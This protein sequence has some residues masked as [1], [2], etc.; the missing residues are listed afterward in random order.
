MYRL[1]KLL[2][3]IGI[4]SRR[5]AEDLIISG[6]V[7]IN[8]IEAKI[9]DKWQAGDQLI[10]NDNIID[11]S[12]FINQKIE[13]IK[14][15]KPRGEVVS[16]QDKFN[17]NNVFSKLPPVT[18]KWISIGRLDIQ[19]TGLILFT[20]DGDLAHKIM[21]P[22][23]SLK[24][25]YYVNTNRALTKDDIDSLLNG[26][27]INKSDLGKFDSIDEIADKYYRLILSTGKNRE[28]RNSLK[29]LN[30][31]TLKLH[32]SKYASLDLDDMEEGEHRHLSPKEISFLI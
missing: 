32:R 19:T 30:I 20:N 17:L 11:V 18:G 15:F 6:K 24:R 16:R 3:K 31:K 7:K 5:A 23:F 10:V 1:Q 21:H 27:P 28:I 22:S 14:Y 4:C 12:N 25:E 8:G 26:V 13:I 2:S 9:G 29:H